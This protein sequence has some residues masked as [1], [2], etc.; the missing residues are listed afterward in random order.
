LLNQKEQQYNRLLEGISNALD[1]PESKFRQAVKRYGDVGKWLQDGLCDGTEIY[2]QG[3]IRLGTV[4][5]PIKKA[6]EASYDLD[7]V[8][9]LPLDMAQMDAKDLKQTVGSR[10][11]ENEMYKKLM[12]GEGKRCWTLEYAEEDGVGFHMD[13]LP[14][15][16]EI[17]SLPNEPIAITHKSEDSQ[18]SWLSSNPRGYAQWFDERKKI[19]FERIAKAQ[20]QTIFESRMNQGIYNSIDEV[21]D[22]RVKTPLQRAIQILKRHRDLRFA[23]QP[24]EENKPISIIITTLAAHLYEQE[25]DTYTALKNIT[26]KLQTH[27]SLLELRYVIDEALA[28]R[29]LITRRGDKWEILNPV[30]PQENFAEYWHE[31]NHARAKAFFH[32]VSWLR[33]DLLDI[34]NQTNPQILQKTFEGCIGERVINEAVKGSDILG[35][36]VASNH[37]KPL[38]VN[39]IKSELPA[40]PWCPEW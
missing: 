8:C 23:G 6:K 11:A 31:D 16:Q 18:Y 35:S 39:I 40:K 33:E 12:D 10:L 32:W 14:S 30:N 22:Y 13:I 25:E 7:L 1:I 36:I 34:L 3:S 2:P 15:A 28:E 24:N 17:S 19:A 37:S 38:Q 5:R 21:P 9:E 29:N 20:K 27:S 26:E 4:V